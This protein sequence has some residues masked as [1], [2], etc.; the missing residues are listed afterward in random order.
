MNRTPL[1]LL[2]VLALFVA[3][4][5]GTFRLAGS[6]ARHE[7]A[8][9]DSRRNRPFVTNTRPAARETGVTPTTAV[10]ADVKLP[11]LGQGVDPKS[12]S[13]ESVRLVRTRDGAIIETHVNTTGSGDAI[14]L[15]PRE[16]LDPSTEYEFVVTDRVTD[17][18]GHRFRP[19]TIRFTTAE[20]STAQSYPV[21]FEHVELPV[22]IERSAFTALTIGENRTL[23]AGTYDGRILTF[24]INDDGTLT[25]GAPIMTVIASNQGPRL[26]TGL[27]FSPDNTSLWVSHGQMKLQDADDW[28]GK[29]SRLSGA[30]FSDYED[31]VIELP[32]AYKDH[33]NFQIDFGPDGAIYFN[34][35]SMTGSGA[36]DSKWA[37]RPESLLTA[38]VLR[39]DVTKIKSLPL[40]ARTQGDRAYDPFAPDAPLTLYATGIRSGYEML[41]HS[42]GSLY[43]AVNGAA[44]GGAAPAST[45]DYRGTPVPAIPEV[46]HT[47]DDLLI[48]ITPGA[49]YGHPNP[50]RHEFVLNGGNPTAG[51]DP[52]EVPDYPVGTRPDPRYQL[53]AYVFGKNFSPNGMIEYTTDALGDHLRG[54]IFVARWSAGDDVIVL[55]P[56]ADGS[57]RQAIIGIDGLAGF[58]DPLDLALDSKTGNLYVAEY[59][60]QR[61][62]LVRPKPGSTSTRVFIENVTR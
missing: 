29:I 8:E 24:A 55:L 30:G 4:G 10:A 58:T 34:Q 33:L 19:H 13:A 41:W 9:D 60:G 42:N 28:T 11:N 61:I 43:T 2:V 49:Y 59:G 14:V 20:G 22:T 31:V 25:P 39:L 45:P 36:P 52:Q 44:A 17:T 32:R 46:Q 18:G 57:I 51:A 27:R 47:T 38:A 12:L 35:G 7:L 50:A 16:P 54:A 37:M 6:L 23:Y 48:R 5:Y 62:S 15:T 26:I 53:P 1:T 56:N 40:S 21:A 3:A